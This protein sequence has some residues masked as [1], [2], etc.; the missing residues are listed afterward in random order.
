MNSNGDNNSLLQ[1]LQN[2]P[3][4]LFLMLRTLVLFV[5]QLNML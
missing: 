3:L 4:T 1:L 2:L 5:G